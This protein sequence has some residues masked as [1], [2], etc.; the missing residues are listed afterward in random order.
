M[1]HQQ[2]RPAAGYPAVHLPLAPATSERYEMAFNRDLH[3]LVLWFCYDRAPKVE[4]VLPQ[5]GDG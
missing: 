4:N 1:Q 5:A 2:Q 3:S